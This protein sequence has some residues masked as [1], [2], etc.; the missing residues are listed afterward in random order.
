[1]FSMWAFIISAL[2]SL[3]AADHG[4]TAED[5][6]HVLND[7]GAQMLTIN[8][9]EIP[10]AVVDLEKRLNGAWRAYCLTC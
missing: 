4:T 6:N 8:L 3:I 10:P 9:V 5:F 7:S 1:M 2:V